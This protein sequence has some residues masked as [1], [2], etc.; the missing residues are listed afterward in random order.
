MWEGIAGGSPPQKKSLPGLPQ[1]V[2]L[3]HPVPRLLCQRGRHQQLEPR[4]FQTSQ[5][6]RG[7]VAGHGHGTLAPG[8][9]SPSEYFRLFSNSAVAGAVTLSRAGETATSLDLHT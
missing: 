8:V 3:T 7:A 1:Q 2:N 9:G 4:P 5:P 6:L